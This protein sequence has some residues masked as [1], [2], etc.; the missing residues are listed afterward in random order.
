MDHRTDMDSES[1]EYESENTW[2][3]KLLVSVARLLHIDDT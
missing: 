2:V 3:E 1:Y